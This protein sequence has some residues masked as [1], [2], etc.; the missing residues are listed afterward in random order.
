MSTR[1]TQPCSCGGARV[2][3]AQ[4]PGEP[5]KPVQHYDENGQPSVCPND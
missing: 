4:R 2:T 5:A 1:I 3:E